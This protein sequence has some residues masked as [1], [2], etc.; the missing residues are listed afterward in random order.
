MS[1]LRLLYD[2]SILAKRMSAI[3][4]YGKLSTRTFI[5]LRRLFLT[6]PCC[7]LLLSA[8]PVFGEQEALRLGIAPFNSPSTLFKTHQALQQHLEQHLKRSVKLYTSANHAAFLADSLGDRFDIIITPPHFGVLN[9]ERGYAPLVRY[10][11]TMSTILVV[12][13]DSTIT[14]ITD[15]HGKRIAFP[16]RTAFFS[17][18]GIKKL[19]DS[20]M[21]ADVDYQAQERPSHAAAIIAVALKEVDAAVTTLGPVNQMSANIRAQLRTIR[22]EEKQYAPHLM[23]LA[24]KSLGSALIAEIKSALNSFPATDKG[25]VFFLSTGYEGY[26]PITEQDIKLV[27]PYTDMIRPLAPLKPKAP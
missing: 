12:R 15:L 8:S 10:R 19:E 16:E 23:T 3:L 1:V 13:A 24:H 17:V 27:Q 6:L 5:M 20:G 26:V 18:A 25:K 7:L 21:R 11:A 4:V 22:F 14:A 2:A 9:L